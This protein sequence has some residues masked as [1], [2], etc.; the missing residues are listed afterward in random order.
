MSILPIQTN[1]FGVNRP[2]KASF[3][4][5]RCDL[6]AP[7]RRDLGNTNNAQALANNIIRIP[8]VI[9]G[10]ANQDVVRVT[11]EPV[12]GAATIV[13]YNDPSVYYIRFN[14]PDQVLQFDLFNVITTE[15]VV[16]NQN[17][18]NFGGLTFTFFRYTYTLTPSNLGTIGA[19]S[20]I[21]DFM[22]NRRDGLAF[23]N[24]TRIYIVAITEGFVIPED[25]NTLIGIGP[26]LIGALAVGLA[27]GVANNIHFEPQPLYGK[28]LQED[29]FVA[30]VR[31]DAWNTDRPDPLEVTSCIELWS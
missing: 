19:G 25:I 1:F 20:T 24:G 3:L 10:L 4:T 21:V 23:A 2:P 18:G 26:F 28:V 5:G 9:P 27:P 29:A 11:G 17:N 12:G 22:L 7:T 16:V 15:L 6:L 30:L 13:G 8:A 31:F 14:P